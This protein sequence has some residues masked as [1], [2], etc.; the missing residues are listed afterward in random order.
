MRPGDQ[1]SVRV[2]GE[3]RRARVVR[4]LDGRGEAVAYADRTR[5]VEQVLVVLHVEGVDNER[6]VIE[7]A[8]EEPIDALEDEEA[9]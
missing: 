8:P 7:L 9:A 3:L 6:L 1:L 5:L 4:M 2:G